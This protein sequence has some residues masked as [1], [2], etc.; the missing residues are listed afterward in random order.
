MGYPGC[1]EG[2]SGIRVPPFWNI[3]A[4]GEPC[5][6]TGHD[7][8]IA[9]GPGFG[10][11]HETTRLCLQAIAATAPR[12]G[13]W[14][15]LDFGSGSGI[16][17]IGAVKLGARVEAVEIDPAAIDHAKN[18]AERNGVAERIHYAHTLD[19]TGVEAFDVVVANILRPVLIQFASELV[20][21]LRPGGPLILSGLVATDVPEVKSRYS[22]LLGGRQ[23][24]VHSLGE[25]R[26]VVF[27]P[28]P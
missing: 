6:E 25:W 13:P 7:L 12:S 19:E 18:N 5:V 1:G 22:S 21:R 17:S 26:A 23:G 3:H 9:P 8:I 15:M 16:L 4:P 27:W 11:E 24:Q 2:F 10:R 20:S 28:S 14:R